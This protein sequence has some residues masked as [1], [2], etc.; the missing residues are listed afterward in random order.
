MADKK[1]R[2]TSGGAGGGDE[3]KPRLGRYE[4]RTIDAR[5]LLDENGGNLVKVELLPGVFFGLVRVPES[6]PET[7]ARIKDTIK[8][9]A[10]QPIVQMFGPKPAAR[11]T[12]MYSKPEHYYHYNGATPLVGEIPIDLVEIMTTASTLFGVPMANSALCNIYKDGTDNLGLHSD[13]SD[14]MRK[15]STVVCLTLTDDEMG[16]DLTI[17]PTD[18][19]IR[20]RWIVT[21]LTNYVAYAMYGGGDAGNPDCDFQAKLKHG[22]EKADRAVGER[23]SLTFRINEATVA[24]TSKSTRKATKVTTTT[25][26]CVGGGG[27]A[28]CVGGGG[29]KVIV[30]DLTF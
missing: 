16:R 19:T 23:I 12:A 7:T 13:A 30:I 17:E 22:I 28:A 15:G 26:S 25:S 10:T 11:L 20:T 18:K 2:M 6:D 4:V 8:T 3:K 1:R 27:G 21:G 5:R 24:T 14:T 9:D 29:K